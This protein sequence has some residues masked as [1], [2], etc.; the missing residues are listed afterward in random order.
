M[1]GGRWGSRRN[2]PMG[3]M[4][5][6]RQFTGTPTEA[7]LAHSPWLRAG[8]VGVME[9]ACVRLQ[10]TE[11]TK[12]TTEP[13]GKRPPFRLLASTAIVLQ[14]R[15]SDGDPMHRQGCAS[16]RPAV[17]QQPDVTAMPVSQHGLVYARRPRLTVIFLNTVFVGTNG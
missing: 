11:R 2:R 9:H 17:R 12:L 15:Q 10:H 5:R 16:A 1:C 8:A 6:T 7:S 4:G 3:P 14:E 13:G